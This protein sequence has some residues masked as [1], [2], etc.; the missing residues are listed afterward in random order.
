MSSL[1]LEKEYREL[2][3]RLFG[4]SLPDDVLIRWTRAK[5]FS[6][7]TDVLFEKKTGQ[8]VTCDIGINR[9][10]IN[11]DAEFINTLIHEMIHVKIAMMGQKIF[12][13]DDHGPLFQKEANRINSLYPQY[14][15]DAG[16]TVFRPVSERYRKI[17]HGFVVKTVSGEKHFNLYKEKIDRDLFI[18]LL[19]FLSVFPKMDGAQVYSFSG[20]YPELGQAA[21]R[22]NKNTLINRMQTTGENRYLDDFFIQSQKDCDFSYKLES[23]DRNF[24]LKKDNEFTKAVYPDF[25]SASEEELVILKMLVNV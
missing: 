1:N 7:K 3:S 16:D 19:Q 21:V 11:S 22:R 6:G 18:L 4:N 20:I 23:H 14:E 12:L 10:Y 5:Y 8:F 9:Y 2:N 24:I 13:T 17:Q 25:H 15:I